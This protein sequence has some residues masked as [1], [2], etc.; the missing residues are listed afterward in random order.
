MNQPLGSG[1]NS[2][3]SYSHS[4]QALTENQGNQGA[5]RPITTVPDVLP[6]TGDTPGAVPTSARTSA[7]PE[8]T[9]SP[10]P[11]S[12]FIAHKPQL[13][14]MVSGSGGANMT[15]F[16]NYMLQER[17]IELGTYQYVIAGNGAA[18]DR[19]AKALWDDIEKKLTTENWQPF[20]VKNALDL[21]G[22]VLK[23]R[24]VTD[25]YVQEL[26]ATL[27]AHLPVATSIL[28]QPIPS[29]RQPATELLASSQRAPQSIAAVPG[30]LRQTGD[31]T[32]TVFTSARTS[33]APETTPSPTPKSVFIA[34]KPQLIEM[35][36][37]SGCANMTN[38]AN[39][40]L[41]ECFIELGTYKYV[42]AGNGAAP[43]RLAK[44]LWDDIEK[45]LT[46]ENWQPAVVQKAL[47]L[48]G[49]VLG[50]RSVTDQYVEEIYQTQIT[51]VAVATR[52]PQHS[53]PPIR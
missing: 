50:L 24:S 21:T 14:K 26:D 17:F 31:T 47:D 41:Q 51:H 37:G 42:I 40:M 45:K 27:V 9:P 11:K 44:A 8:T 16:A 19:L 20:V 39:Y 25:Q 33:A 28:H 35:V 5:R 2:V 49:R 36:C 7:A 46:T 22:R 32:G 4:P 23:Q 12:V 18:P 15:N 48:T 6:Q 34:H 1:N 43:D 29:I 10:T 38:L 3:Y 13:I 53:I 52:T 30:V